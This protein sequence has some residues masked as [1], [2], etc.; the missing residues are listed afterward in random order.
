MSHSTTAGI[1]FLSVASL[2]VCACGSTTAVD[3]AAIEKEL[4][5]H[6]EQIRAAEIDLQ[7]VGDFRACSDEAAARAAASS[8]AREW[9]TEKC[10][11]KIGWEP[12]GPVHG[13]YWVE[14]VDE[15][16]TVHGIGPDMAAGERVHVIATQGTPAKRAR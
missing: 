6:V 9:T 13:G 7:V 5:N 1:L 16:F 12:D 4:L 8:T 3:D 2:G 15:G 14:L 11:V 10:W